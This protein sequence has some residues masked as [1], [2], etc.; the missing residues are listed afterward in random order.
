MV[1]LAVAAAVAT[2]A[3]ATKDQQCVCLIRVLEQVGNVR[4]GCPAAQA[5]YRKEP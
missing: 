5:E 3:I 4:G 2:A 1:I